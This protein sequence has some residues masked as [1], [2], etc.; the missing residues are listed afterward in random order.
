MKRLCTIA[1]EKGCAPCHGSNE[2]GDAPLPQIVGHE[3][4]Q[5][6]LACATW[7]RQEDTFASDDRIIGLLLLG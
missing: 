4:N 5:M 1:D 3:P 2:E 7:A 6:R